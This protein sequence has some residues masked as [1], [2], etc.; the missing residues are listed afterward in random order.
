MNVVHRFY[1]VCHTFKGKPQNII[2]DRIRLLLVEEIAGLVIDSGL[3]QWIISK[4][5]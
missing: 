1:Y 2:D 5:S 4:V 3:S